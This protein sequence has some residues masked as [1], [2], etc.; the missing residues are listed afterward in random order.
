MATPATASALLDLDEDALVQ[1]LLGLPAPRRREWIFVA[2]VCRALR[3]AVHRAAVIDTCEEQRAKGLPSGR[4][5]APVT[6][7]MP[8]HHRFATSIAGIM[9]TP[10]RIVYSKQ[11]L[12]IQESQVP[13]GMFDPSLA[14]HRRAREQF[15]LVLD[16][17]LAKLP[18]QPLERA[19]ARRVRAEALAAYR[20]TT[21][22]LYHMVHLA[23]MHTLRSAFF[24][25]MGGGVHCALDL[26][27]RHHRCL[28]FFAA[29]HGRV[30]VL[31]W[32][33][34]RDPNRAMAY[35]YDAGLLAL[36]WHAEDVTLTPRHC[37]PDPMLPDRSS[38]IQLLI[39]RP[40][41]LHNRVAVLDWL[42]ATQ[43][44]LR[45]RAAGMCT[46]PVQRSPLLSTLNVGGLVLSI[47]ASGVAA[48]GTRVYGPDAVIANRLQGL[49]GQGSYNWRAL[50]L[51][52]GEAGAGAAIDVLDRLWS[53]IVSGAS[54]DYRSPQALQETTMRAA[55]A[56]AVLLTLL[57]KPRRGVVVEWVVRRCY[58]DRGWLRAM[59]QRMCENQGTALQHH[60]WNPGIFDLE[61]LLYAALYMDARLIDYVMDAVE[62]RSEE[63][64]LR[65]RIVGPGDAEKTNWLLG[66][67]AHTETLLAEWG[68]QA[69]EE[70][71]SY[72]FLPSDLDTYVPATG[73][74]WIARS[75]AGYVTASNELVGGGFFLRTD[76]D[77]GRW[78]RTD[79]LCKHLLRLSYHLTG[80]HTS[81][82]PLLLE[83]LESASTTLVQR[84]GPS[85]IVE[86][87]E[88]YAFASHTNSCN[89]WVP[90][91]GLLGFTKLQQGVATVLKHWLLH[92]LQQTHERPAEALRDRF[93]DWVR[94]FT[95][96]PEACHA[97]LAAVCSQVLV[98][99]AA[100]SDAK[101]AAARDTRRLVLGDLVTHAIVSLC[102]GCCSELRWREPWRNRGLPDARLRCRYT[103]AVAYA[104]LAAEW[105]LV[106]DASKNRWVLCTLMQQSAALCAAMRRALSQD[107]HATGNLR[108]LQ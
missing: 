5:N 36:L 82:A 9:C 108:L 33:V 101:A 63:R 27:M 91:H 70:E 84:V 98:P 45:R 24:E 89:T 66:E 100:P 28:V 25:V 106:P 17:H 59:A 99:D 95:E 41:A 83:G 75:M 67:L 88:S 54:L 46:R 12:H 14:Q 56:W 49:L 32:L 4:N 71:E 3:G 92:V 94:P 2:L 72:L 50:R 58:E 77:P 11:H 52:I 73:R 38:D 57:L 23:P 31:D 96:V 16:H 13:G 43:R 85:E 44:A 47:R 107:T 62:L 69:P 18:P 37:M 53:Q 21:R 60:A 55:V 79:S 65:E 30:D 103:W 7:V 76:L 6:V 15:L 26:S 68:Y 10:M 29:A 20:L 42:S 97:A 1:V 19:R 78:S 80:V 48:D 105:G 90:E 34:H 86:L 104:E 22:A 39:A 93:E 35:D 8:T 61:D 40:A 64:L 102:G 87:P 81:S 51:L 74:G